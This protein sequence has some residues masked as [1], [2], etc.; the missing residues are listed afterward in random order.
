[1]FKT[2]F[3]IHF[4]NPLSNQLYKFIFK[5]HVQI[6]RHNIACGDRKFGATI[7]G[8]FNCSNTR[9]LIK[10]LLWHNRHD[11]ATSYH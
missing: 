7:H 1:M 6:W 11:D 9:N 2:I 3:Q 5:I 10:S 8:I 4:R